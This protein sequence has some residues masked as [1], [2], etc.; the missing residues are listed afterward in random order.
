MKAVVKKIQDLRHL[1][2]EH[3]GLALPKICVVGDQSTGKSSLIEGMSE[4]KVPR[5]AGCCTRCPLEINL[6]ES[7]LPDSPWTCKVLLMKKYIYD[8]SG[9]IK[10]A[11]HA[12]PLGPWIG[13][14]PEEFLFETLTDKSL[15]QETLKWAQ[16]AT[17]NPGRSYKD[18]MRGDNTDTDETYTQV[19]FSPNVVR[20]DISAPGFPNLSFY[21]LPGVIN[22]AEIDG[23]KYL[24]T[25]V[26]NLVKEYIEADNCIAL[27]TLPMTDDATN[28]SAARIIR[29][30]SGAR[31]RTL[32]VLT[33]PDRVQIGEGYNQWCEILRGQKFSVGHG[34]YVVRNNPDPLV[35]HATARE[36]ELHFFARPPWTEELS[37]YGERFGTRRLQAALSKLLF[38]QIQDSLPRIIDQIIYRSRSVDDE[39]RTLPDPPSANIAYILCQ[40]LNVFTNKIK[41]HIDGGSP[42]YQFLKQW[43]QVADQFQKYLSASR[44]TVRVINKAPPRHPMRDDGA[45]EAP[46]DDE[47]CEVTY[48]QPAADGQ[49]A[50]KRKAAVNGG[51]NVKRVKKPGQQVASSL[52]SVPA[53]TDAASETSVDSNQ[54]HFSSFKGK[55]K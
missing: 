25:L 55:L 1:G 34:Y 19:K 11:T 16:L 4:I 31:S 22:V 2:I 45:S 35:D 46:N 49:P 6:S 48:S 33:K 36:E 7:Q 3:H 53:A 28:S 9:R 52:S 50:T 15:V 24:V 38:K 42:R 30:V 43:G 47:E 26:E 41:S 21:D 29:D 8:G 17:L 5:S 23:E 13:Q 12:K 44:P 27:L 39:L 54:G 20:L 37:E 32:G 14:D 10:R 40:K 51:V 18:F